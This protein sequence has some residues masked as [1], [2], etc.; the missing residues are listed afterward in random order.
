MQKDAC[1]KHRPE[2]WWQ[3]I[4]Q[5]PKQIKISTPFKPE[6]LQIKP[7]KGSMIT[8]QNGE[9]T[10][11]RNSSFIRKLPSNIAIHHVP[12]D[13]EEQSTPYIEESETVEPLET[14]ESH[15]VITNESPTV[16]PVEPPAVALVEP[17]A[18][19]PV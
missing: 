16:E 2:C 4:N 14:V 1:Q 10:V 8:A 9:R 13:E 15:T 3:N 7:S 12:S 11:T 18:L 6:P 5:K 17:P 19:T